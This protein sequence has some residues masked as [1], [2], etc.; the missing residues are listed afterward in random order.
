MSLTKILLQEIGEG[1]LNYRFRKI[2]EMID[3]DEIIVEY[4]FNTPENKYTVY[5][6][7]MSDEGLVSVGFDSKRDKGK[8]KVVE[9]TDEHVT[10]KVMGTVMQIAK[11]F[12]RNYSQFRTFR[13]K[14]PWFDKMSSQKRR[15]VYEQF[16]KKFFPD[17]EI[18]KVFRDLIVQL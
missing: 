13:I 17:V 18:K 11:E 16:I 5:F 7:K 8:K 3:G 2:N 1:T 9:P 15:K 6:E 12:N 10:L 14:F 4:E